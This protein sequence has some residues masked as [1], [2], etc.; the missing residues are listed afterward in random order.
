MK[1]LILL[2]ALLCFAG[3]EK[4]IHEVRSPLPVILSAK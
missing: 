2:L 4:D 1:R 3:C